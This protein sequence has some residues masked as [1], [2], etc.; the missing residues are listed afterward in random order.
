LPINQFISNVEGIEWPAVT[1]PRGAQVLALVHQLNI[2]QWWSTDDL[3]R[4]QFKQL[5]HLLK[6]AF[7][8]VPFYQQ[9]MKKS[10]FDSTN[11]DIDAFRKLPLLTRRDLQTQNLLSNRIIESHGN[12]L[13]TQTSGSTGEPV[14]FARSEIT[15]LYWD[16]FNLR[17]LDWHRRDL[18]GR[19]AAIRASAKVG[20]TGPILLPDWG[21][22]TGGIFQ[23]GPAGWMSITM[24][25]PAQVDWLTKFN[26]DYLLTFP[27]NALAIL[28]Y[29]AQH[30]IKPSRLKQLITISETVTPELRE[31]SQKVWQVPLIDSY[32]CQ[33]V[34][35]IAS[36]CPEN[37]HYHIQSEN[38]FIE[39]LKQDGS[40][41]LPGET[42]RVVITSLHNF[43]APLIRYQIRDY[44]E[45]GAPC[46]CGRGL[47]VLKRILGRERN[48]MSLP[49]GSKCW[50]KTG[51]HAYSEIA[52]AVTQFQFVQHS[53]TEIEVLLAVTQPLS[54]EEESNL[55][56]HIL[57]ALDYPFD[58]RF[59]FKS[60]LPRTSG[61]KFEDFI[62]LVN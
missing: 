15:E 34:G 27:S 45:V 5:S 3:H 30:K 20:E 12:V 21:G 32:S 26:P 35:L 57:S 50:P 2:S 23:T 6:Y 58:I 28:E 13:Q 59:T 46:S 25:V 16:A 11:F 8:H 42:G 33:E 19:Y 60:T 44:A 48:M 49:D 43:A 62:S 61:G 29:C 55:R 36:Q 14:K 56:S 41:C 4:H 9:R 47:P 24:P 38:V 52:P 54:M 17:E 10:G 37:D 51:F 39:I 18:S 40:A 1:S 22:V 31:A 53:V 7:E